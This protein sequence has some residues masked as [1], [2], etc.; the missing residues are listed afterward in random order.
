[1][2]EIL[3]PKRMEHAFPFKMLLEEGVKLANGTDAPGYI[4]TD[5]LRDIGVCVV[6]KTWS[7]K[8]IAPEERI[9]VMDAIR[10]HTIDAAY[11]EFAEATK[12]S[13]EPGKLADLTV[14]A[15]DPLTVPPSHIKDI[16]V[17]Y[18]VVDGKIVYERTQ[19]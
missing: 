1:M 9:S 8:E 2:L 19:Q 5:P 18:T 7:G 12:G 3:G 4:P 17:D 15:E 11:A 13:I 14:L 10:L 6:R 16:Q